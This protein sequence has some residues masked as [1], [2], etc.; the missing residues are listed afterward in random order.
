MWG[1]SGTEK[2]MSNDLNWKYTVIEKI[3]RNDTNFLKTSWA[4]CPE[5]G[6]WD[7]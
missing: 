6:T 5:M 7:Y 3:A 4:G 1:E 2:E